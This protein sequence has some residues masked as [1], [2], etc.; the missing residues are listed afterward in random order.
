[1]IS[2]SHRAPTNPRGA[3]AGPSIRR[4][5]L[6]DSSRVRSRASQGIPFG[7]FSGSSLTGW[8]NSWNACDLFECARPAGA[9]IPES[10]QVLGRKRS[11]QVGG[12][13][14]ELGHA[15]PRLPRPRASPP[16]STAPNRCQGPPHQTGTPGF[17][18]WGTQRLGDLVLGEERAEVGVDPPSEIGGA[19][20]GVGAGVGA[21]AGVGVGVGVGAGARTTPRP[22]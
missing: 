1:M 9:A 17:G 13:R 11:P 4:R 15:A 22:S 20:A 5:A 19:G 6:T 2:P 14:D 21:G 18:D 16:P 7:F 8:T 10:R 3:P 12:R